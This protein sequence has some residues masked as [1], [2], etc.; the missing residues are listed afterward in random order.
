[1]TGVRSV[2]GRF[3]VEWGEPGTPLQPPAPEISSPL[4]PTTVAHPHPPPE[5]FHGTSSDLFPRG[6]SPVTATVMARALKKIYP[7]KQSCGFPSAVFSLSPRRL[8]L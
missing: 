2:P 6:R 4:R 1:M 3:G 5:K 7:S 8:A